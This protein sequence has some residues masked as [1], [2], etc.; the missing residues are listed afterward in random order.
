[1]LRL[2]IVTSCA[3][4][5]LAGCKKSQP[6]MVG[7]HLPSHWVAQ[8]RDGDATNR[9]RAAQHLGNAGA[10]DATIVPALAEAVK[11]Q[12]PLVRREAAVALMKIGPAAKSAR[13]AVS[14]AM[15]DGDAGVREA[16]S[17]ALERIDGG[18][19]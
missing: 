3:A 9:K 4:V 12:D 19:K 8:L 18:K 7:D 2:L 14:E 10:V 11:D 5:L 13:G 16:A 6:T 1:M 17:K 15:N